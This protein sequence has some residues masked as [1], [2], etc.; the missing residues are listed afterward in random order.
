M[1]LNYPQWENERV[2]YEYYWQKNALPEFYK[3]YVCSKCLYE[4]P[5][6]MTCDTVRC[7]C[8]EFRK[9]RKQHDEAYLFINDFLQDVAGY[10]RCKEV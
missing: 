2:T 8:H 6:I 4:I 9:K 5:C 10:E 7:D 1:N 3:K